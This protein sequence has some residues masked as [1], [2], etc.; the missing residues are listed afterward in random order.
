MSS[1]IFTELD[2]SYPRIHCSTLTGTELALKCI[3]RIS[4]F[5]DYDYDFKW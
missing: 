5:L 3:S 2:I 1:V 4:E